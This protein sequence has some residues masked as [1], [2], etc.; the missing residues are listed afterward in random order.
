L[1]S[2]ELSCLRTSLGSTDVAEFGRKISWRTLTVEREKKLVEKLRLR[3][4]LYFI[5][6]KF[7][8][9]Y[10]LLCLILIEVDGSFH[11]D[12]SRSLYFLGSK[13]IMLIGLVQ[14]N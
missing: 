14:Q 11:L 9:I 2:G 7:P 5:L 4:D 6:F 12:F 13:H 8:V 1:A 10:Q 3:Q